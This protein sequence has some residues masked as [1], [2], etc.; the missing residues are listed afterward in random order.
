MPHERLSERIKKMPNKVMSTSKEVE[1]EES[2]AES[3]LLL[4]QPNRK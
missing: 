1:H 2:T 3:Q 4:H